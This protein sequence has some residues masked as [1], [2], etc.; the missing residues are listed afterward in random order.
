MQW[1]SAGGG[2]QDGCQGLRTLSSTRK[3]L[4]VSI[5]ASICNESGGPLTFVVV[6]Y[7]TLLKANVTYFSVLMNF[8][9]WLR[10]HYLHSTEI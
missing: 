1:R 5:D 8:L 9:F 10:K 4:A 2:F 7:L 3:I 6:L